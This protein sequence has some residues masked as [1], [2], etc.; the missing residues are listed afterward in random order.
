MLSP[1]YLCGGKVDLKILS[2]S[3]IEIRTQGSANSI[4]YRTFFAICCLRRRLI[5]Q[6]EKTKII[7]VYK[8][9]PKCLL[10]L[11]SDGQ[12]ENES[13]RKK[14]KTIPKNV[15]YTK[16]LLVDPFRSN[17][18]RKKCANARYG[19]MYLIIHRRIHT[20]FKNCKKRENAKNRFFQCIPY[21]VYIDYN[22][23]RY[24]SFPC[25]IF[26][27]WFRIGKKISRIFKNFAVKFFVE[28]IQ[29]CWFVN[30]WRFCRICTSNEFFFPDYEIQRILIWDI[31][32]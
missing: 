8:N 20:S 11:F 7:Q 15:G 1:L 9:G 4:L 27:C 14:S 24:I 16:L 25:L 30:R 10:Y 18:S 31:F 22:N 21:T 2:P 23:G 29:Y 13:S 12:G 6:I 26:R 28:L 17:Q 32:M 19:K 3:R 5:M